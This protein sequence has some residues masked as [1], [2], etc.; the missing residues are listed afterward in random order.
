[1]ENVSIYW[2]PSNAFVMTG[3]P[4][5][6]VL[7]KDALTMTNA[8]WTCITVILLPSVRT[9]TDLT[10]ASVEKVSLEM[11]ST[12]TT[13]T[14]VFETMEVVIK[15]LSVSTLMEASGVFVM[16]ASLA[17][18]TRVKTSTS[19]RKIRPCVLTETAS[20][21]RDHFG[22]N[23]IWATCT[24]ILV[25]NTTVWILTSVSCS[26]MFVFMGS[27]RIKMV[28]SNATVMRVSN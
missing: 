22:V 3:S 10:I 28:S 25:M 21:I 9:P 8:L 2:D 19:V 4:S 23:V 24:L 12:V 5:R 11:G 14:S 26:T 6:E 15:M 27:V 16:P 17:M 20:T 7:M 1:M 13:S 18:A